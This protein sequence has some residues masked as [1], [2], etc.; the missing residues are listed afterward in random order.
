MKLF[1]DAWPREEAGFFNFDNECSTT[2]DALKVSNG[3][4]FQMA[5]LRGD[6]KLA[7]AAA[8]LEGGATVAS[9]VERLKGCQW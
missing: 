9:F 4:L 2:K 8:R 3:S 1:R 6:Q 7:D 5:M